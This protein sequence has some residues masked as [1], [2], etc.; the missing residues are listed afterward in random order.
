MS[1]YFAEQYSLRIFS[2]VFIL[3]ISTAHWWV[4]DAGMT[5]MRS[6]CSEGVEGHLPVAL[7]S[8][9]YGAHL[10]TEPQLACCFI[11]QITHLE[12]TAFK[13]SLD[14]R[15]LQRTWFKLQLGR[16]LPSRKYLL[17]CWFTCY[18]IL[19]LGSSYLTLTSL[20]LCSALFSAR[21][22]GLMSSVF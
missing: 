22:T 17:T 1:F 15:G 2:I 10:G 13:G 6:L 4:W 16:L 8:A 5:R 18:F 7:D 21:I 3:W 9:L 19:E 11:L 20:K 12:I 14:I